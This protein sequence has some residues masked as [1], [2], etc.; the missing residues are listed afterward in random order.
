MGV[1]T[2]YPKKYDPL[3]NPISVLERLHKYLKSIK[4]TGQ[5]AKLVN[6]RND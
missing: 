4:K 2:T 3:I 1:V 5:S 6:D